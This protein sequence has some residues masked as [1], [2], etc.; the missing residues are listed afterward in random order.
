MQCRLLFAI[1][2]IL[3]SSFSYVPN[4]TFS[5]PSSRKTFIRRGSSSESYETEENSPQIS[6][7]D[8]AMRSRLPGMNDGN[9]EAEKHKSITKAPTFE[10]YIKQRGEP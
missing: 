6:L 8:N 10:E 7:V 5:E 2:A 1:F 4:F 9:L 3:P